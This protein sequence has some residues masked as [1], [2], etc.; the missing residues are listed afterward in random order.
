MT[1]FDKVLIANRGEIAVRLIRACRDLD[2]LSVAVYSDADADALHVE[3]ADEAVRIG[4]AEARASYLDG[5]A[6]IRAA[7]RT[8]AGAI[9]PGYGFLSENADFARACGQAGLVFVGPSAELIASM[10]AKSRAKQL[11]SAAGVACVPG[12]HGEDQS[13]ERFRTEAQGIGTPLLIK[14]SAGG[15]GRGMRRVDDLAEL[16]GALKLAREEARAAFGDAS[17]LLER[18]IE[19]PRHIEVQILGDRHGQVRHLFERDCSVQ[20]HYQKLIEEAPAPDL[21]PALRQRMLDAALR[22]AQA[23]GY[24]NAGTV[25]FVV[26]A[27]RGEAY[28]LEMNTRLQVEHPVTEMITGIDLAAW[29]LRIAAGERIDFAQEDLRCTGWAMEARIAAEDPAAGYQPQ[30]GRILACQEPVLTGVRVDSG[31]RAGSEISPYYDSM[32]AKLIAHAPDRAAARRR[33][34]RALADFQVD[35]PKLNTRFLQEILRLPAF[36]EGRHL[37]SLLDETWPQGWQ[38]AAPTARDRACAVLARHL[39]GCP[40]GPGPWASLGAWRIGQDSGQVGRSWWYLQQPDGAVLVAQVSGCQGRFAVWLDGVLA[41]EASEARLE[42]GQLHYADGLG[43]H[44]LAVQR[45]D[46]VLCLSD[47]PAQPCWRI[48]ASPRAAEPDQSGAG[49]GG[50]LLAPTPGQVVE[51]LVHEGDEVRAGQPLLVLEAMKMLQQLCA[52]EDGVVTAV[53]VSAGSAVNSGDLLLAL[54]ERETP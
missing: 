27:R 51:I 43:R 50:R 4:P 17:L 25:E 33:L 37:T 5:Q 22:L 3:R 11:A 35:G 39:A 6:L 26:D 42:E 28:F 38:P 15:G 13:D 18:F 48:S 1:A 44:R 41:L 31:V 32:L 14:A 7:Q 12:Y 34:G 10:G 19:A 36:V 21:D 40:S 29:Q 9:H 20:R 8:G 24:D 47:H 23:I 16:P 53:P 49:G 52:S 30:T 45:R 2:L 46:D 54:S